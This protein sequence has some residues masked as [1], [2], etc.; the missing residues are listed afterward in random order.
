MHFGTHWQEGLLCG[1]AFCGLYDRWSELHPLIFTDQ[2]SHCRYHSTWDI[3]PIGYTATVNQ[4]CNR[5]FGHSDMTR[6]VFTTGS[7]L[8]LYMWN[9]LPCMSASD[10]EMV[11]YAMQWVVKALAEAPH[12]QILE[13]YWN[14]AMPQNN[15]WSIA[16]EACTKEI[17]KEVCWSNSPRYI[18]HAQIGTSFEHLSTTLN[19]TLFNQQW[20]T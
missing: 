20:T 13:K 17:L 19:P 5:E 11:S 12:W 6:V 14:T 2:V 10:L 9:R 1:R 4:Y 15:I 18:L 7:L 16:F 8:K 3:Y